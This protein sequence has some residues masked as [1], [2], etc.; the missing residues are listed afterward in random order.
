MDRYFEIQA[1]LR[2]QNVDVHSLQAELLEQVIGANGAPQGE[3]QVIGDQVVDLD[4]NTSQMRLNFDHVVKK[5]GRYAY[6]VRVIPFVGETATEDNQPDSAV[7]VKVLGDARV[8]LVAGQADWEYQLAKVLFHRDP[9]IDLSCWLQSL[10]PRRR[11][12]GN[13]PIEQ[14]PGGK[15]LAEYDVVMLFDP[16]PSQLPPGWMDEV[17]KFVGDDSRGLFYL[18]GHRFSANFLSAANSRIARDIL[19]VE[20]GDVERMELENLDQTYQHQWEMDIAARNVDLSIMR[21]VSDPQ[22]SLRKWRSMPGFYWSFPAAEPKPAGR[23]LIQ[24]QEQDRASPPRPLLVAGMYGSGRVVYM[25]FNGTWRWRRSPNNQHF[26]RGFWLRAV[27]FLVEGQSAA[28]RGRG[29][30][31]VDRESYALG[32]TIRIYARRVRDDTYELLSDEEITVTVQVG[33]GEPEVVKLESKPNEAGN[34][35]GEYSGVVTASKIGRYKVTLPQ[36]NSEDDSKS[37]FTT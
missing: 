28:S 27:E 21:F 31:E 24:R 29:M 37:P 2:L 5:K 32:D 3:P 19:P 12:E 33:E 26:Y 23:I 35:A 36:T 4:E 1:Q 17:K 34:T 22:T 8:L 18:A 11:Q 20:F 13:T 7:E 14:L 30:L 9:K 6:T 15:A 25:G 10:D 16:D